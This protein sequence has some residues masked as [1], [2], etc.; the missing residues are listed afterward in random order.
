[1]EGFI[2]VLVVLGIVVAV[3]YFRKQTPS[4]PPKPV[5]TPGE[6]TCKGN[7][8]YVCNSQGQWELSEENSPYCILEPSLPSIHVNTIDRKRN[9]WVSG[10]KVVLDGSIVRYTDGGTAKFD[11][12]E[13]PGIHTI[14]VVSEE[15]TQ[16]TGDSIKVG[17]GGIHVV[18]A[19]LEP[20]EVLCSGEA[21]FIDATTGQGI[22]KVIDTRH[23]RGAVTLI[24]PSGKTWPGDLWGTSSF[25]WGPLSYEG[26]A[27]T[28]KV[29]PTNY[30]L[31]AI[32]QFAMKQRGWVYPQVLLKRRSYGW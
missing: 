7:D 4:E 31:S 28:I 20:V 21:Q 5:C 30:Y 12:V 13:P 27:W 8:F 3:R 1:M 16:L 19:Y 17:G 2:A 25:R 14:K 9:L 23:F 26:G 6:T 15:Y 11:N 24:S 32:V 22:Q 18:N 29:E 10:L